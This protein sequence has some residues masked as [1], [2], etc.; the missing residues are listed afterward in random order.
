GFVLAYPVV[1]RLGALFHPE[2][3]MAFLSALV[4][5][6]VIRA[7]RRGWPL[8]LG[9]A[10][11][12]LCGLDFLTRQ[13]AVVV[14]A[15]AA[16]M[17]LWVG[18]RQAAAF[19]LATLGGVVLIAGP[20]LGYAAYTWGN[21]LQGNLER[22]GGMVEGG[23][24]LSFYVSFPLRSLLAHPY[25]DAF[26]NQLLPQLHAD[27]WS[28]WF[29]AFH[30]S[31]WADP[32]LLDRITASSQSILGLVGDALALGGLAVFGVPMLVRVLRRRPTGQGGVALA[33]LTLLTIVGFVALVAQIVRYP[34]AGGKEI[35]ASYLMF[36]A[37]AFAVFSVASWLAVAR[38][39]RL[40][41]IVLV[42]A[43]GLYAV[44]YPVS[45]GSALSQPYRSLPRL[46]AH[47]GY[48]D[49]GVAVPADTGTAYLG[50]PRD[51]T[52]Y[53][54]NTGTGTANA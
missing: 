21:P 6:V 22:P 51:V 39:H 54:S 34:Q 16:P 13:R 48:V 36:A 52:I 11:G 10:A 40:A 17:A 53:V 47:F 23:E 46:A 27:L 1:L 38:R 5:W 43:A 8:H 41:G 9:G 30:Q 29:G 18:R 26:G 32:P 4:V 14:F 19:A 49:L 45:L 24:P 3:T 12:I 42:V 25:R 15:C 20:W 50:S 31:L 28:D 37:P 44:S 33:F 2:T 35:K 7:E